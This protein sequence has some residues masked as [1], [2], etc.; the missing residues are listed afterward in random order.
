MKLL[1]VTVV[2][3]ASACAAPTP[4]VSLSTSRVHF[5]VPGACGVRSQALTVTNTGDVALELEVTQGNAFGASLSSTALAVGASA[6]VTVTFDTSQPADTYSES[7]ELRHGG[8]MLV[9]FIAQATVLPR[10]YE[11]L[12]VEFSPT[13]VGRSVTYTGLQVA[14]GTAI[15]SPDDVAFSVRFQSPDTPAFT[16]TPT[17]ARAYAA[18]AVV[19]FAGDRCPAAIRLTGEGVANELSWSPETVT[20]E[21]P[22]GGAARTNIELRNIAPESVELSGFRV[23]DATTGLDAPEFSTAQRVVVPAGAGFGAGVGELLVVFAPT[24]AGV[25]SAVL[26]ATTSLPMQPELSIP[27]QATAP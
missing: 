3:L 18:K 2:V 10:P 8:V 4:S 21:A 19:R 5:G 9:P 12:V 6:Q 26:R 15:A 24:S 13:G 27:L 22:V 25:R 17:E 1:G 20:L 7:F 23:V 11:D 14:V 16:F